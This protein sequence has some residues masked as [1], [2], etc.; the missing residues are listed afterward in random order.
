M[1]ALSKTYTVLAHTVFGVTF[2]ENRNSYKA[3]PALFLVVVLSKSAA[4]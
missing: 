1:I 3:V 4:R 2:S